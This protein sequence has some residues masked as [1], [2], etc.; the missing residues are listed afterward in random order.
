LIDYPDDMPKA[1]GRLEAE[2]FDPETWK[3][4]YPNPAFRNM[5]PDDAFW[6][7]RI[8]SKFGEREVRA[9]V[10][11]AQFSEPA[12]TEYMTRT[13]M[14]RRDK[15]LRTWLNQVNPVVDLT[16]SPDG[17]L[18]FANAAIDA[19]AATPAESYTLQ[20]FRFDNAIDE[21]TNVGEALTVTTLTAHAPA[22]VLQGQEYIG[23]VITAR[24]ASLPAWSK[25]ATFYF[26]R[27]PG[28]WKW[29]GAER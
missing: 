20:W 4:E 27:E 10:E 29:V 1:V 22:A 11:K 24:H 7:A 6:A 9:I 28:G 5:R 23:V 25:P 26:R 19:G 21:K 8:V 16:L 13:I 17:V 2:S 3:P 14:A 15:V 12:A 18:S